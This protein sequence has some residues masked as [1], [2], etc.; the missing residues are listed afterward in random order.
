MWLCSVSQDCAWWRWQ[1]LYYAFFTI[2]K[3]KVML[4]VL[5]ITV[6]PFIEAYEEKNWGARFQNRQQVKT[7]QG[8][9]RGSS[10]KLKSLTWMTSRS[11]LSN[12]W[13]QQGHSRLRQAQCAS[14]GWGL[15]SSS[16]QSCT[17]PKDTKYSDKDNTALRWG[18]RLLLQS[19]PGVWKWVNEHSS[20]Y[21]LNRS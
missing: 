18:I 3:Q 1:M 2:W 13:L 7:F 19:L 10:R 15:S 21:V 8:F 20:L 11:H 5:E 17:H 14:V 4:K 6:F 9:S 16:L 12:A